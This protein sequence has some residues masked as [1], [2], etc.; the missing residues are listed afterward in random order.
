MHG[1]TNVYHLNN[2]KK[3]CELIECHIQN[4]LA[5]NQIAKYFLFLHH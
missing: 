1:H 2:D 3:S 5:N 4:P